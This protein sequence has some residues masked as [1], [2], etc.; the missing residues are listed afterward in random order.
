M[1]VSKR[2]VPSEK[3]LEPTATLPDLPSRVRPSRSKKKPKLPC[4]KAVRLPWAEVDRLKASL[5]TS[6]FSGRETGVKSW[7]KLRGTLKARWIGSKVICMPSGSTP[8]RFTAATNSCSV[9]ICS[10]ALWTMAV[11]PF[12]PTGGVPDRTS[13]VPFSTA[14]TP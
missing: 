6:R 12:S 13:D 14:L 7:R 2:K 5:P 1:V 10:R 4:T 11:T 3:R 9:V 8:E